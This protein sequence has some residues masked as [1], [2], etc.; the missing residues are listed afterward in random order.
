[1]IDNSNINEKVLKNGC[2]YNNTFKH[3]N[4]INNEIEIYD[5]DKTFSNN[6]TISVKKLW[7]IFKCLRRDCI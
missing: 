3:G 4:R 2:I 6:D 1:M 7:R 5:N